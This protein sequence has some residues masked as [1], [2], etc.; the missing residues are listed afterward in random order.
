MPWAEENLANYLTPTI[1]DVVRR[2]VLDPQRSKN[3]LFGRPRIF[4]DM[5]SSQPLCF[6]LFAE[7]QQ[8]LNLATAVFRDLATARVKRV[9][10]IEFEHS[11]GRGDPRFL[12]DRSA[13]DVY[14]QF[15][16]ST[17]GRGFIGIEVK[18][19]EDMRNPPGRH[20]ERYDE[21]ADLMGCFDAANLPLIKMKPLQQ[22]WRDHMLA[23]SLVQAGGYA[24]GFFVFVHPRDNSCCARAVNDYRRCLKSHETFLAWTLEDITAAIARHTDAVWVG[25][26]IDRY[27]RFEKLDDLFTL[28]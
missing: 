12:N 6:N 25:Q 24:D 10:S 21:V 8:D 17:G 26:L 5:L 1:R 16:T 27:L 23:G 22:I 28:L 15:A 13:F 4:S 20:R 14:V 3:K 7:L 18:Y 11:P 2:E 19:H 9:T